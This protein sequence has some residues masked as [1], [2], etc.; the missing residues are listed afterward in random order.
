MRLKGEKMERAEENLGGWRLNSV[1]PGLWINELTINCQGLPFF[2]LEFIFVLDS[3]FAET[4]VW[5][6]F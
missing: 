3:A 1:T 6:V 4:T 5:N 2:N